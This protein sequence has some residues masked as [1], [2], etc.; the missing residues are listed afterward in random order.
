[1][2]GMEMM[3]RSLG[4]DPAE[5][6]KAVGG[7]VQAIQD[8]DARMR[9]ME[10]ALVQLTLTQTQLIQEVLNVKSS[11]TA[12]QSGNGFSVSADCGGNGTSGNTSRDCRNQ[13][14]CSDC[15]SAC[16]SSRSGNPA[17]GSG[18]SAIGN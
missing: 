10:S 9:G 14:N 4:L 6:Q 17:D 18:E 7:T 15:T 13:C 16:A 5:I 1:M 2:N 3:L 8:F 12:S 11:I